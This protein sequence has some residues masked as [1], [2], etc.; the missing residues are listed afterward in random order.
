[1]ESISSSLPRITVVTPS[2]NQADYLEKCIKSVIAQNYPNLEYIVMDGGSTDGSVDIIK[3]YEPYIAYWQSQPDGGQATALSEGFKRS[4]GVLL[5]WIN[6]DDLFCKNALGRIINA[7]QKE[8]SAGLIYGNSFLVDQMENLL[9][10]LLPLPTMS[11]KNWLCG[12]PSVFQGSVFFTRE[13]Y[14]NV[15]G[16]NSN[17]EYAIEYE[18]FFKIVKQFPVTYVPYFIACFRNQPKSK[19]NTI[20]HIGKEEIKKILLQLENIDSES[21]TFKARRL[22]LAIRFLC[23][24][25]K[26]LMN[27]FQCY[28]LAKDYQDVF[29]ELTTFL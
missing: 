16:I 17:L 20:R 11:Y 18:L 3:H 26:R 15:G 12:P 23:S 5:S 10:P 1:M 13:A 27:K 6:S 2:F 22:L 28:D 14:E 4:T 21:Y 29:R 8:I 7:Y 25:R 19:T 9:S 24:N